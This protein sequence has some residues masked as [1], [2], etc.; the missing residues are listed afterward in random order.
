MTQDSLGP[1][2]AAALAELIPNVGGNPAAPELIANMVLWLA[3]DKACYVN[4]TSHSIDAGLSAGFSLPE[5]A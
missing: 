5:P 4:G 3:S 1:E 2:E